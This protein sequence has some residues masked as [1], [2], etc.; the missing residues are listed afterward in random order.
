MLGVIFIIGLLIFVIYSGLKNQSRQLNNHWSQYIHGLR[1][2]SLEFYKNVDTLILSHNLENLYTEEISL[3]EGG[4][5]S[6]K[7]IYLR[8]TWNDLQCDICFAPFGN[9]DSF[10]SW[11]LWR[12]P[13]GLEAF[14]NAIPFGGQVLISI[15][16]PETYY[17]VDSSNMFMTFVQSNLLQVL[18]EV[19]KQQ[20][21][22][23]LSENERYPVKQTIK[24]NK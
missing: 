14:F 12:V 2:S 19:M 8:L 20:N 10:V 1:Y 15:F 24:A 17:R 5:M 3:Y 18:D 21:I 13:T 23:A 9:S 6:S 4:V 22:V 7:R 16:F 11:W